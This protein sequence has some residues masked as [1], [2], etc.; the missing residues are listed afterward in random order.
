MREAPALVRGARSQNAVLPV[1]GGFYD[2]T[3][4]YLIQEQTCP[5]CAIRRTVRLAAGG[6]FCFNCRLQWST[7]QIAGAQPVARTTTPMLAA[8][9]LTVAERARMAIYRAAVRAGFYSDWPAGSATQ[10]APILLAI[11]ILEPSD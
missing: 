5:R 11:S 8:R 1:H 3:G 4:S 6:C 10:H 7:R 2:M 9:P